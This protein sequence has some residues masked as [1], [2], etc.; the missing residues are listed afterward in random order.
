MVAAKAGGGPA[1]RPNA[2]TGTA[3][4]TAPRRKT[5][6]RCGA[7]HS[8]RQ[9]PP[10]VGRGAPISARRPVAACPELDCLRTPAA[11]KDVV[12]S[13]TAGIRARR[14]RRPRADRRQGHHRGRLC[15][16]ARRC[17]AHRVRAA[18]PCSARCLPAERRS[19]DRRGK[20]R[21]VAAACRRRVRLGHRAAWA[22]R[23]QAGHRPAPASARARPADFGQAA[24]SVRD[25][26]RRQYAGRAR[27]RSLAQRTAGI[28]GSA[29][30]SL[31]RDRADRD[32]RA[33]RRVD[34]ISG[35]R[36]GAGERCA[37]A[38]VPGLDRPAARRRRDGVAR[39][40]ARARAAGSP[41][42][43]IPLS[44]RSTAKPARSADSSMRC[45]GSIIRPRSC[46]SSS[47]SS[48]MT[49]RRASRS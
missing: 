47:R 46:R 6:E 38:D 44:S 35:R 10:C 15:G 48:P 29:P 45:P 3:I 22:H 24:T 37:R 32:R 31:R 20:E 7:A 8:C 36:I 12:E 21:L 2:E 5:L 11:A 33:G 26:P 41:A 28:V 18:R 4:C 19:I 17:F 25:A 39:V 27:G 14:R 43:S 42:P 40:E 13:G 49:S 30:L 1:Y 9:P 16:G 34:R 23:A